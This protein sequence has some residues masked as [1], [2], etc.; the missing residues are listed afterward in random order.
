MRVQIADPDGIGDVALAARNRLDVLRIGKHQLEAAGRSTGCA[1]PASSNPGRLHRHR[2]DVEARQPLRQD[3]EACR[4]RL[5][6]SH[7]DADLA[8]LHEARR[9]HHRLFVHVETGATRI[10]NLVS[11]CSC[12]PTRGRCR[13]PVEMK[14]KSTH[15]GD[16]RPRIIR[17]L[18]RVPDLTKRGLTRTNKPQPTSPPAGVRRTSVSS[19]RVGEAGERL[20]RNEPIQLRTRVWLG[21]P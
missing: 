6:G 10:N 4:R 7:L 17:V 12:L 16:L 20:K 14:S 2:R 8:V 3:D 5:E 19:S 9:R 13:T 11:A 15:L 21:E 1:R 18:Q